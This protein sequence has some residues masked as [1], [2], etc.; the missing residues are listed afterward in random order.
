M[1]AELYMT[2]SSIAYSS[3]PDGNNPE[4]GLPWTILDLIKG[5]KMTEQLTT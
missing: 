1:T 4:T 2:L 3:L 5:K